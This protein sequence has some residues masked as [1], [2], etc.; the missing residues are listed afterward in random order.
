L[1]LAHFPQKPGVYSC[2]EDSWQQVPAWTLRQIKR[3]DASAQHFN[4]S[5]KILGDDSN[6]RP[7]NERTSWPMT[8]LRDL[9]YLLLK[10]F[11]ASNQPVEHRQSTA[12]IRSHYR[13]ISLIP[14]NYPPFPDFVAEL[15]GSQPSF[16]DRQREPFRRRLPDPLLALE[17]FPVAEGSFQKARE[18]IGYRAFLPI[19]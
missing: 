12:T 5:K 3:T 7:T 15:S 19:R 18:A 13:Q 4:L 1:V 17:V 11:R 8:P 10:D 2:D 14:A 6:S 16:H 9:E